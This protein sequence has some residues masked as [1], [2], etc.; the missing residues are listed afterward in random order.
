MPEM[1]G[2]ETTRQIRKRVGNDV[3][4]I[5]LSA[6][7]YSEIE[8]EAREAGVDDLWVLLDG[9]KVVIDVG[10]IHDALTGSADLWKE[11]GFENGARPTTTDEKNAE[12]RI[13]VLY[14]ER[15]AGA[16]NCQMEF[17]LPNARLLNV[18]NTPIAQ[19][20]FVKVNT[21]KEALKDATFVLKNDETGGEQV[22]TSDEQGTVNF[23]NLVAGTYTLTEKVAPY[24]IQ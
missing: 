21:K 17:T 3:T 22:V 1:D 14:M 7:D 8:A 11:L 19:M 4:I 9:K 20:S 15:G 6:Y 13:T 10:G 18:E 5:I 23:S 16:S 12:H 2:I 24:I